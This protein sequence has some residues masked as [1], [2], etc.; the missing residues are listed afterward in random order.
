[1]IHII[2]SVFVKSFF[3]AKILCTYTM[4]FLHQEKSLRDHGI[5]VGALY[6]YMRN[7]RRIAGAAH[8]GRG[9]SRTRR[10]ADAADAGRQRPR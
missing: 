1:L 5:S 6:G 9:A 8:R 3:I 7:A 10:I 4:N 2:D